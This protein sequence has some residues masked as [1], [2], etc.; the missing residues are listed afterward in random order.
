MYRALAVLQMMGFFLVPDV[1]QPNFM[2]QH[3]PLQNGI[4]FDPR[5]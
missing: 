4:H 3:V 5:S 2:R 1:G